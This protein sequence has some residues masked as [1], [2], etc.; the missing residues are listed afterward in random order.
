[1][2]TIIGHIESKT[3]VEA[4]NSK[5]GRSL[6]KALVIIRTIEAYPRTLCLECWNET[7]TI[8]PDVGEAVEITADVSSRQSSQDPDNPRWFSSLKAI[9]ITRINASVVNNYDGY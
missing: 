3:E 1:M 8:I 4:L 5:N 7:A 6:Q 2:F 9:K